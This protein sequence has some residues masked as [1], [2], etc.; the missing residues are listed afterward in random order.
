[1]R[2]EKALA[3]DLTNILW[4]NMP[5]YKE[6]W[7]KTDCDTKDKLLE[8]LGDLAYKLLTTDEPCEKDC[9]LNHCGEVGH[10][11]EKEKYD[12]P[13][14]EEDFMFPTIDYKEIDSN[15]LHDSCP[16]CDGTGQKKNGAGMCIHMIS[17]SCKKCTPH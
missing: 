12:L 9:R 10:K 4:H 11:E 14:F 3:Y 17:C 6:L 5:G 1:M 2:K 15:C 13:F 8:D 16:E 7:N